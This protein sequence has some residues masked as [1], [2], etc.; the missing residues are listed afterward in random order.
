MAL[1]SRSVSTSSVKTV[2]LS[3]QPSPSLQWPMSALSLLPCAHLC[4]TALCTVHT[5][6]PMGGLSSEELDLSAW[7]HQGIDSKDRN[8][9]FSRLLSGIGADWKNL[10][11]ANQPTNQ[12]A[13]PNKILHPVSHFLFPL[14]TNSSVCLLINP[15]KKISFTNSNNAGRGHKIICLWKLNI[16]N[17]YLFLYLHLTCICFCICNCDC[18]CVC[19]C[20]CKNTEARCGSRGWLLQVGVVPQEITCLWTIWICAS[21]HFSRAAL[22]CTQAPCNYHFG[23]RT[24][25]A[26]PRALTP[27]ML[28]EQLSGAHNAN[29]NGK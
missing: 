3:L 8:G 7:W 11:C 22:Q 6:R 16:L 10:V 29:D 9:V 18:I 21:A 12:Q 13:A 2:T 14:H 23:V 17:L 26:F 19:I 25:A 5:F 15:P 20:I 27:S 4:N 24:T 28:S 1:C